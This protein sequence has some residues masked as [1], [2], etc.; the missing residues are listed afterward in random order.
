MASPGHRTNTLA[1]DITHAGIGV[2]RI[3]DQFV[4]TLVFVSEAGR[5]G[6]DIPVQAN[7]AQL[8]ALQLNLEDW[9]FRRPALQAPG[10]Q[11]LEGA[12]AA[13]HR[14]EARLLV[15]GERD[16]AGG[17]Y[18]FIYLSGPLVEIDPQRDG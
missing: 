17:G 2:A 9:R 14:G 11:T 13:A 16:T 8:A 15:R 7:W 12:A 1:R 6:T 18:Q 3:H 4:V 10:G 5:F